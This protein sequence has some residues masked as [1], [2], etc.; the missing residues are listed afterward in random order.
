MKRFITYALVAIIALS[1]TSCYT[2]G[3]HAHGHL[4][5]G[6]AK[7]IYGDKSAKRHA[8]GQKKKNN[9]KSKKPKHHKHDVYYVPGYRY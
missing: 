3:R 6:Q 9:K 5:P 8:P 1:V 4:P 7:K 2:N